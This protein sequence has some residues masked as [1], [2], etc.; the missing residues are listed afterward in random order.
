MS[1]HPRFASPSAIAAMCFSLGA[2]LFGAAPT[3]AA[4][5][6]AT[7]PAAPSVPHHAYYQNWYWW[8]ETWTSR[9]ASRPDSQGRWGQERQ[10]D[11]WCAS[12]VRFR[13]M[14]PDAQ[15]RQVHSWDFGRA[16][17]QPSA[18]DH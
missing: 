12:F 6:P 9:C 10:W 13:A 11:S 15:W 5:G 14:T 18:S 7:T 2:L 17:D 1:L 4:S 16:P 3:L 8:H